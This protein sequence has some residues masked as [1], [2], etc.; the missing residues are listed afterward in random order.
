MRKTEIIAEVAQGY[1]G[2]PMLCDLLVKAAK[3][4]GADA[5][6]FQIFVAEELC[7]SDY[8][9][10]DL[11]KSLEMPESQWSRIISDA[12]KLGLKFYADV[13]GETS[14]SMLQ[15]LGIDAVKIHSTDTKNYTLLK[16]IN[17]SKLP[18]Y[19]STGGSSLD[20]IRRAIAE[21][22]NN[23]IK[24]LS[25]FQAEPNLYE[26]IELDKMEI[27]LKEFSLPVGYADHI[28]ATD[29]IAPHVPAMAILKGATIIE[30]HITLERTALELEDYIS[31]LNPAEFKLMIE[32]V[33]KV[34]KFR[35]N[36]SFDLSEREEAY[37]KRSKR[38][39]LSRTSI[40]QGEKIGPEHLMMLRTG[41]SAIGIMDQELVIGK[42]AKSEIPGTTVI[43][44]EML[45]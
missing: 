7:T 20:E 8:E 45:S 33:E 3:H 18:V 34:E 5:I 41:A 44:E 9:Y 29:P 35:R 42:V 22:P 24:L 30:K 31:A 4:S 28:D 13:F 25:G 39:V 43:Q 17:E 14:F 15:K 40:G 10:Y 36:E 2:N 32:N 11:Y 37:R 26:D 21:M 27:L 6:K 1:A 23:E 19:L 38:F 16:A 12:K